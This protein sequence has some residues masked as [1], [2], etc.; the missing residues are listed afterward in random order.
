MRV[1]RR[2]RGALCAAAMCMLPLAGCAAPL[3]NE[4]NATS[5][6][7]EWQSA[8]EAISAMNGAGFDCVVEETAERKQVIT[9]NPMNKEPFGGSLI[10]CRGYQVLLVDNPETYFDDLA[11]DCASVTT[12]ELASDALD[13][14]IVVGPNY[15]MSGAEPGGL[16]PEASSAE[17]LASAFGGKAQTLRVFYEELCAG[18]PPIEGSPSDVESDDQTS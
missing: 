1:S 18:V 3:S 11:S 2:A 12:Q 5:G 9:E 13:S 4:P 14:L 15:I 10:A 7:G 16:F 8:T 6:S 17:A